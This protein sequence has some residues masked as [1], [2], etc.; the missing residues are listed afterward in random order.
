MAKGGGYYGGGWGGVAAGVAAGAIVGGAVASTAY[1]APALPVPVPVLSIPRLPELRTLSEPG[2]TAFLKAV[3]ECLIRNEARYLNRLSSPPR[4]R[5]S[6]ATVRTLRPLG[7]RFRGN[8]GSTVDFAEI[9]VVRA[10]SSP[11]ACS[12]QDPDEN[13][14]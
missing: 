13:D 12:E 3:A 9:I 14:C 4:K 8:D 7:S 5:G 2:A 10:L 6:R 11:I 1:P